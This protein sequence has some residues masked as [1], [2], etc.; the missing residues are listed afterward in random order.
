MAANENP[1][2]PIESPAQAQAAASDADKAKARAEAAAPADPAE[3]FV[4]FT[5]PSRAMS[6]AVSRPSGAGQSDG[7][8]AAKAGVDMARAEITPQ[9][10]AQVGIK[11]TRKLEWSAANNWRIPASQLTAEQLHYLF[12]DD[13]VHNG[14]RFVLVD[15]TGKKVDK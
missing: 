4:L 15:G 6:K 12:N 3:R 11:A 2:P 9:Q 8:Y 13:R 5:S 7:S 14:T 1:T 10:W